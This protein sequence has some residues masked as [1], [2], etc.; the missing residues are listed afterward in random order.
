ML[1]LPSA[2]FPTNPDLGQARAAPV[3]RYPIPSSCPEHELMTLVMRSTQPSFCPA[4]LTPVMR[5]ARPIH[6]ST[7]NQ[8]TPLGTLLPP[9]TLLPTSDSGTPLPPGTLLPSSDSGIFLPPG[10]L[11]PPGSHL[12]LFLHSPFL[13]HPHCLHMSSSNFC[14]RA[15]PN[16]SASG[17][18]KLLPPGLPNF[19]FRAPQLSALGHLKTNF[20][21]L[22]PPSPQ[23][24]GPLGRLSA[25][26]DLF[27]F[28]V[29]A[30]GLLGPRTSRS[31]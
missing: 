25:G 3:S 23:D 19:L 5:S 26:S 10:T 6:T 30:F 18:L 4:L 1:G 31:L 8:H 27:G 11:L 29:S 13:C 7:R 28:R 2:G 9:G 20:W 22:G 17:H 16:T 14:L 12:Q 21:V 24:F 15:S